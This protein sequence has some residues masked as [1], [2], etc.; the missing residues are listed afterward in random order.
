M[1]AFF[2][3]RAC[4][5]ALLTGLGFA[6]APTTGAFA[7][8]QRIERPVFHDGRATIKGRIKGYQTADYIFSVG[9]GES[10]ELAFKPDRRSAYVNL[11]APGET[12]TAFFIGSIS[13][14]RFEGAAPVS[15]DYTARV[16]LMRNDAR[17][18]ATAHYTLTLVLGEKSAGAGQSPDFADS[19]AGGPDFW[20]VAGLAPGKTLALREKPS[21]DAK[22]IARLGNGAVL[23]NLGGRMIRGQLWRKVSGV[24]ASGVKG[25]PAGWVAG[26]FL[27][28]AAAPR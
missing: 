21:P 8:E 3:A 23:K 16:Y 26:R 17:R 4:A 25:A 20:T 27:R 14:D 5:S 19:L 13:G 10:I 7:S 9:A 28:E 15:G 22:T 6:A 18:G 1:T 2:S 24:K 12:E 11:L